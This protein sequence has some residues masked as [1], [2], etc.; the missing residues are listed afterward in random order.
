MSMS[1]QRFPVNQQLHK[2]NTGVLNMGNIENVH[3]FSHVSN[4]QLL[5]YEIHSMPNI[6][7][8]KDQQKW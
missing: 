5:V 1:M 7:Y 2:W 4:S 8:I 6:G 3:H